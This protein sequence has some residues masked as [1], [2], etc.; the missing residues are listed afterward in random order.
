M[1]TQRRR[2]QAEGFTPIFAP[3]ATAAKYKRR[4]G[5]LADASE[6]IKK[7]ATKED[8][9]FTEAH[10]AKVHSAIKYFQNTHAPDKNYNPFDVGQTNTFLENMAKN[11]EIF[12]DYEKATGNTGWTWEQMRDAIDLYYEKGTPVDIQGQKFQLMKIMAAEGD[13][14]PIDEKGNVR[15]VRY[16]NELLSGKKGELSHAQ[17]AMLDKIRTKTFI[18]DVILKNTND[19]GDVNMVKLRREMKVLRKKGV[20]DKKQNAAIMIRARKQLVASVKGENSLYLQRLSIK[21]QQR[22]L[23]DLATAGVIDGVRESIATGENTADSVSWGAI[24]SFH[25]P[26]LRDKARALMDQEK[27]KEILSV[28]EPPKV[29]SDGFGT[30]SFPT[31]V[32]RWT[33][34]AGAMRQR[35]IKAFTARNQGR[36]T[37]LKEPQV[38]GIIKSM[39]GETMTNVNRA[40]GRLFRVANALGMNPTEFAEALIPLREGEKRQLSPSRLTPLRNL[41]RVPKGVTSGDVEAFMK[42]FGVEV[43]KPPQV[44]KKSWISETLG[45]IW[46]DVKE[47]AGAAKEQVTGK[48]KGDK[49][50]GDGSGDEN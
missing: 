3:S 19:N 6:I 26:G 20:I 2:L 28:M 44:N 8:E 50:E 21:R 13:M 48:E 38:R 7:Y 10:K 47:M 12:A 18:G 1:V 9:K 37:A 39:A 25:A 34:F 5:A 49:V 41:H 29:D 36:L 11:K 43:P 24:D 40:Y 33:E 4:A 22:G 27:R 42:R 16:Y 14:S 32:P 46:S 17:R 45:A 15:S 23:D 31:D 35:A 30:I